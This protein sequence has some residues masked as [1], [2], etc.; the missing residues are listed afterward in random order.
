MEAGRAYPRDFFRDAFK[1]SPAPAIIFDLKKGMP[2]PNAEASALLGY[3]RD[4]LGRIPLSRLIA[5]SSYRPAL[6]ALLSLRRKR[7]IAGELDLVGKNGRMVR[8]S[9]S[10]AVLGASRCLAVLRDVSAA[11]KRSDE[12]S[13]D[14]ARLTSLAM[15]SPLPHAVFAGRKLVRANDAFRAAFPWTDVTGAEVT[16]NG[17]LGKE[18][19]ALARDLVRP[20]PDAPGTVRA[21]VTIKDPEGARREFALTGTRTAW[22]GAGA[23]YITLDD[24]T[25]R[26]NA[27][28][29]LHESERSF[30]E[31]CERQAGAVSVMRDGTFVFANA[32]CALLFAVPSPAEL[33]GKEL[34]ALVSPRERKAIAGALAQGE[35][36]SG[37]PSPLEYSL[38]SADGEV[39]RIT[40]HVTPVQFSGEDALLLYHT[41]TT[42]RYRAEEDLRRHS[43]AEAVLGQLA[44]DIHLSL[45]PGEVLRQL[46]KGTMKWLGFEAGGAYRVG[47]DGVTLALGS[48]D[49][50]A[51]AIA[52]KLAVQDT[53]EGVTGLVWKTAE[54]LLLDVQDYP[55]HIPYKS[56][57]EGGGTR[58]VLYLPL[59]AGESVNAVLLLTST[60]EAAPAARDPQLRS[61]VARHGGDA[62]ANALRYERICS[63]E[64]AYRT[65]VE[66][67]IDTVY[68]CSLAGVFLYVSPRVEKLSGYTPEEIS[69]NPDFWRNLLHPDERADYSRRISNQ[70][71]GADEFSLEYRILPKG[72]ASYRWVRDAVRYR[73][74]A[75]GA[76]TGFTGILADI[77]ARVEE[78]KAAASGGV[79][80]SAVLESVQEGV[81]ALDRDFRFRE[82]NRGME[83]I[84]GI[85]REDAAGKSAFEEVAR[86][87]AADFP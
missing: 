50:L 22:D 10:L 13:R 1:F 84:T 31:I 34:S 83:L 9:Y 17:F 44:H 16:L 85:P 37:A 65:I 26:N 61:A 21:D 28:R 47:K 40:A 72:K 57:F 18:N 74:D 3:D 68:E 76:V 8:V 48:V 77:T 58:T 66:S 33:V 7:K 15:G 51:P 64:S 86:F 30:R 78:Q 87:Q 25:T 69:R 62:M 19:A 35:K 36:V 6:R 43:R 80:R 79:F 23:W 14:L 55:A 73:R 11:R 75:S 54:P 82:W 67:M 59:V 53:R 81:V 52:E 32:A 63:A 45:E 41:D 71:A 24:V 60:Q 49:S 5:P 42:A 4:A 12:T 70:A 2:D 38:K 20:D 46:L 56:L 39:R 29:A 27:L